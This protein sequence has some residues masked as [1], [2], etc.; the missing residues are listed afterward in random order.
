MIVPPARQTVEDSNELACRNEQNTAIQS[1]IRRR[2]KPI[3]GF[4]GI[5]L[6]G[7]V[8]VWFGLGND[9]MATYL[10]AG[11]PGGGAFGVHR[12]V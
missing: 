6:P 11:L 12:P 9:D 2:G 7:L 5:A 8:P 1:Q 4:F 10:G 3:R